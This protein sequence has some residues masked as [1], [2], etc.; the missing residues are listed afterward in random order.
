MAAGNQGPS[1]RTLWIVQGLLALIYLFTGG[2]KLVL[3]IED[4]LKQMPLPL[5]G[6]F[7]RFI[8]VCEVLGAIGLILPGLLGIREGVTPVAAAAL[9][10]GGW[11]YNIAALASNINSRRNLAD[12]G[13]DL[14]PIKSEIEV[15]LVAAGIDSQSVKAES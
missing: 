6:L 2:M 15:V 5:P 1:A 9:V 7:L 8:G 13:P 4:L 3:P 10:I 12:A 11:S 14:L